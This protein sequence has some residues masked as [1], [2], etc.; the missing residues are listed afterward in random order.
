MRT[1]VTV[2]GWLLLIVNGLHL[3]AGLLLWLFMAG[4]GGFAA[5][6][7]PSSREA[8]IFFALLLAV[9]TGF[10]I[11]FGL[12]AVPGILIGW[13]LLQ[14]LPWARIGGIVVCGLMLF[15]PPL[16]TALGIYG[17]VVL[18]SEETARLFRNHPGGI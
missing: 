3:M 12:L 13:G 6:E 18:L 16:G 11:Y 2:L 14:L 4:L 5:S 1:H 7:A 10:L 15:T 8:P 9:G 17:L